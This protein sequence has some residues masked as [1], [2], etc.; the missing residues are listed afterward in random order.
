M[1]VSGLEQAT[2]GKVSVAGRDL[3]AL[4]EDGLALF[5]RDRVGIVFQAFHLIPTMTA[6]ENV[7]VPLE[8]AGRA[9]AFDRA[10]EE[11]E[12]VGLGHRLGH[13]P[14]PAH[15]S[16]TCCSPSGPAMGRP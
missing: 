15:G 5:R 1:V 9:D 12:A 13:Y 11:L 8:F 16:W 7:A 6:L 14:R 3:T 10:G 4:D 2:S